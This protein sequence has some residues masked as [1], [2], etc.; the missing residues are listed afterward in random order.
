MISAADYS[1][2]DAVWNVIDR[3]RRALLEQ[4]IFQWDNL[5][6]TSETV[7]EDI[8]GGHLYALMSSG[9]CRA[10]VTVDTAPESQYAAIQWT[11][12]EPALLA[13]RLCVDPATQGCGFGRQLITYVEEYGVRH[14]FAG[15][16]LDAYSGNARALTFY[17]QRGYREAGQVFF[18]RRVLPFI[19]FELN[20]TK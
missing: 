14:R 17:R 20:L 7:A 10:V 15:M 5:Y 4:G 3:C 8:A 13:H 12:A 19:Y 11:T 16:R 6:P 18:P 1:Q 9:R 2:L